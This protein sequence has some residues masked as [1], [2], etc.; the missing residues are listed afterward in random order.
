MADQSPSALI[1]DDDTAVGTVLTQLL[2][3]R[4]IRADFVE[5]GEQALSYLEKRIV[6]LVISDLRMP[7]MDGS[8][9]LRELVRLYPDT[10]VVML[11][12]DGAVS[13]AV[14]AMKNGA[15]DFLLKPFDREE[16]LHVF[17]KIVKKNAHG[18]VA[19]PPLVGTMSPGLAKVEDMLRKAAETQATVLLRGE[20]G[21][22]KEVAAR[23]VH[24]HSDRKKAPF[25][26]VNCAALPDN[27]LESELFGY[28]RGAF[29]GANT[30]KFG[31]VDLA[32]G[33]TLFLDEIGDTSPAFQAKL[34]RLLQEREFIRLGGT[35]V[36]RA[37]VRFV[38][39]THQN[40][41]SMVQTGR[42][43]E[44][45]WYRLSVVPVTIPPLRER[46][47]DIDALS[48]LF[49]AELAKEHGRASL[50]LSPD[51]HA[52]LRR[53]PWPGNVRELK[54]VLERLVIM[55]DGA[56][57]EAKA[58]NE[59]LGQSLSM[60]AVPSPSDAHELVDRRR[61]AEKA[62]ILDALTRAGNNRSNAA[63]LLGISR[64]TLYN[65]LDELG[66]A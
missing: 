19:S 20:S 22:G 43:R 35:G 8:A 15:A 41:E 13:D 31:R 64:R 40:L 62:A 61:D 49:V 29:T 37:N 17:E 1:V 28:E 25:V 54:N 59:A 44:D 24:D 53:H 33:G 36:V 3:Q 65:K 26:A 5:S 18:V 57:I 42:F 2:R 58:I 60:A 66:I 55:I 30:R 52:A 12:A 48:D 27:L 56:S 6:D 11:T 21:A 9:L 45:L 34:L 50:R 39:A 46:P 14:D 4:G 63:K 51:A 23:F 38:A 10:P 16:V 47:E 32:E 7:K